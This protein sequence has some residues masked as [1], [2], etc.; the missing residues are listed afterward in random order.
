MRKPP[1]CA[2]IST[3]LPSPKRS[4]HGEPRS[5]RLPIRRPPRLSPCRQIDR[6]C[7]TPKRRKSLRRV[8]AQKH[9]ITTAAS[10]KVG[11]AAGFEKAAA[12]C[13]NLHLA[14]LSKAVP[15]RG[16]SLRSAP[17]SA[18]AA[19]FSMSAN[20]QGRCNA[21]TRAASPPAARLAASLLAARPHNES[22]QRRAA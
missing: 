21:A 11:K 14:A 16:T 18:S 7:A 15:S 1:R 22:K 3:L 13:A 12:L 19:A 10:A 17:H 20:R 5:A 8:G 6:G 4:P 9:G 2:L